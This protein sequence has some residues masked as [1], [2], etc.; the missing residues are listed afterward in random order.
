MKYQEDLIQN[1][2]SKLSVLDYKFRLLEKDKEE[3]NIFSALH[4][5]GFPIL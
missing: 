5:V 2:L 3:F 4:N 1:F